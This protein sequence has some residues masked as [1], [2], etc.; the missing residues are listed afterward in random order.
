MWH[1][2]HKTAAYF[3]MSTELDNQT[4]TFAPPVH[5]PPADSAQHPKRPCTLQHPQVNNRKITYRHVHP[6][7]SVN[8]F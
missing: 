4:L 3:S 8:S 2:A 1:T 5:R 6:Q 7:V